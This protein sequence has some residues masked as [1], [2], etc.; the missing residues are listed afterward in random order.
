MNT[1]ETP[2]PKRVYDKVDKKAKTRPHDAE[3]F[4]TAAALLGWT[5]TKDAHRF[6]VTRQTFSK[7]ANAETS[8]PREAY[9]FLLDE[10][11]KAVQDGTANINAA[12]EARLKRVL[13]ERIAAAFRRIAKMKRAGGKL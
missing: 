7:W 12:T 8:A 13:D 9:V 5:A 10:V 1:N 2:R 4:R 11:L 3:V 6:K